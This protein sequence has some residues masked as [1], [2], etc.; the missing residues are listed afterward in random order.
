MSGGERW[1]RQSATA[2][3]H[4]TQICDIFSDRPLNVY[5][6]PLVERT[7]CNAGLTARQR[8]TDASASDQRAEQLQARFGGQNED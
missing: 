3:P 2:F 8:S 1:Q 4:T 5:S 6:A 7:V